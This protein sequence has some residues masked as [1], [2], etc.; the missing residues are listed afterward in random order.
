MEK[1]T[2]TVV[3]SVVIC[4]AKMADVHVL[5]GVE[6]RDIGNTVTSDDVLKYAIE[7]G[8]YD[9]VIVA[10]SRDGG[11]YIASENH[12]MDAVVGKLMR[13]VNFLSGSELEHD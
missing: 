1:N 3:L 6:R 7:T 5:P 8:V 9:A 13:A 2:Q 12:D 4:I 11:L 10:K